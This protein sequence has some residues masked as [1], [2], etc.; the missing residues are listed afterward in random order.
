MLNVARRQNAE[1]S[2]ENAELRLDLIEGNIGNNISL[3]TL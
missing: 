1:L 3:A 2:R